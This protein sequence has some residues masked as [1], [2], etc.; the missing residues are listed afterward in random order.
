MIVCGCPMVIPSSVILNTEWFHLPQPQVSPKGGRLGMTTT[1][2]RKHDILRHSSRYRKP[3]PAATPLTIMTLKRVK[4]A[5]G[6]TTRRG[7]QNPNNADT[8]DLK[9]LAP[10]RPSPRHQA[11]DLGQPR[12]TS[13]PHLVKI[14]GASSETSLTR[15]AESM[16]TSSNSMAIQRR[17][18]GRFQARRFRCRKMLFHDVAQTG[19]WLN[20]T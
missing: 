12:P 3:P 20:S 9:R 1:P 5:S 19:S 14:R 17:I 16:P 18:F 15:L 7:Q 6:A 2:R 8:W 11:P 10:T 4:G 13:P